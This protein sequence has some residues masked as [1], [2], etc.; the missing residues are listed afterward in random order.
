VLPFKKE[1]VKR[2]DAC[3]VYPADSF[4]FATHALPH[5]SI[6]LSVSFSSLLFSL[7]VTEIADEVIV[8]C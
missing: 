2:C 5:I 1:K 8:D 4:I 3:D 7:L 6:L